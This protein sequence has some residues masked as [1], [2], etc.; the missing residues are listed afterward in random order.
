MKTPGRA[1]QWAGA[2]QRPEAEQNY[3]TAAHTGD[4]SG[5][6]MCVRDG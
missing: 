2:T 1:G 6:C 3:D 5:V 4:D